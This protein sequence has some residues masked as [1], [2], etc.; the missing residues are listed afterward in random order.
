MPLHRKIQEMNWLHT[1]INKF[2]GGKQVPPR[3]PYY[4][5]LWSAVGAFLGI[6]AVYEIG[7]FEQ[8]HAQDSL[9]LV[10]SFGASA[11]LI[12]GVPKSPY[13]QPRN[14]VLGHTLSAAV[15]V[16]CA[17][18]L[19]DFPAISTALAVSLAL[20]VMHLTNSIHPPGGA[21]ALIAVIGSEQIHQMYFWYVLSPIFTGAVI[22]LLVGLLINNLSPHRRYPEFW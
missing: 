17:I 2:R 8:F 7:H 9:F 12:Y 1:Y 5:V 14:L 21:T 20:T 4:E 13:A 19:G 16:A 3:A 11:I 18:L 15:G 10:G 22:M 6:Y